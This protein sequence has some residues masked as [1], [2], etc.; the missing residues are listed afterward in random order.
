MNSFAFARLAPKDQIERWLMVM[1]AGF[2]FLY[3][4]ILTLGP[5][6]RYHS[7]NAS[8]RW[9]HWLGVAI[10]L[11]GF[12]GVRYQARLRLAERDPYLL[13]CA[14]L[15]CGWGLLTIWRLDTG[16]G[17]RQSVWL[18]VC[19]FCFFLGL[20]TPKL[21]AFLRRYKYIWLTGGLL[22]TA[23]TFLVG[24]YPGGSGPRLWLGC[25]GF[26]FQPSEPLKVLLVVYLAAYLADRL[27]LTFRIIPLLTPTLLL[28]GIALVIL[29]AQ[30][31]LGTASLFILLY[32]AIIY[33]ASGQS[34]LLIISGI[35][36]LVAGVIGYMLFGVIHTRVNIWIN[37]WADPSG[38]SYQIVQS[39][40]AI[41]S[42]GVFGTGPGLGSP[43]VVPISHSDFIFTAISEEMG[44]AGSLAL[45][46]LLGLLVVR[47]M[48]TAMRA[49]NQFQRY[50]AAGCS[51]YFA[52]QS[53]LIIGGNVRLLP[54]TG[55]TLPFVSY[56]GS[57]LLTSFFC[58]L[59][60][61]QVSSQPDQ[62][63]VLLAKPAPYMQV[64]SALL[65]GF[66]LIG[67]ACGYW[68]IGVGDELIARVDNPR[69]FIM[70]RFS[71]RGDILDRQNRRLVITIGQPGTFTRQ[72]LYPPIGPLVGYSNAIYGQAGLEK[73][74]DG[75]LRGLKGRPTSEI[76][77]NQLLY[78]QRPSGLDVR[79]SI[80]LERQ[81]QADR[82]LANKKGAIVLLNA[83]S[84]EIFVMASHPFFDPSRINEEW[85]KWVQDPD[86]PLMNRS[87]QGIYPPGAALGP[88]LL[89]TLESRGAMPSL[90][91]DS[92]ILFN[93]KRWDCA[94]SVSPTPTWGEMVANGCP[95]ALAQMGNEV[96]INE[97]IQLY[98]KLGFTISPELPLAV[99][100]PAEF[101]LLKDPLQA[102]LGQGEIAITPLQMALAAAALTG[103][104]NR[105]APVL[106]VSV[107]TPQQAWVILPTGQSHA[108]LP[109][110][111]I[112]KATDQLAIPSQLLWQTTALA[113][114]PQGPVTW[115]LAGT[116]PSWEGVPLAVAILLEEQ[117]PALAEQIGR[118]LL[119]RAMVP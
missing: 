59:L 43:G 55:V 20:R 23:A 21:I 71:P 35:L 40:I 31:D 51:I 114:T 46:L 119:E 60:L 66:L 94:N 41:A 115:Y 58:L 106:A 85:E 96:G 3:A 90:P 97:L 74:L 77:T 42:G 107:N 87:T 56:G 19:L 48:L 117:N 12:L 27:P 26:Y 49:V 111:G 81:Q 73:S 113:Q 62:E 83:Q 89:A 65:V 108:V 37:P 86:A 54:L 38:R 13:P 28:I 30:R 32:F 52:L 76:W 22:L 93:Q 61:L 57:S 24:T 45:L 6:V 92:G 79:L 118:E 25:C 75:Y 50:L 68:V 53:I 47:G 110:E 82:L 98:Q 100:N 17:M 102:I 104:G 2:V 33:L 91:V 109:A 10:W 70:D 11:V 72:V 34:R 29:V 84:G 105:P 78:A 4:L 36:I 1:A 103:T 63:P 8:L 116:L 16:Y 9:G 7:W 67:L 99:A 112:R 101:A 44:L 88:F 69:P 39:L 95:G 80:D 15:L 14:A 5:I 18:A 64:S